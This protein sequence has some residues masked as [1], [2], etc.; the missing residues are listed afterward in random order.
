M[1]KKL[2]TVDT[3]IFGIFTLSVTSMILVGC[4][5]I[6]VDDGSTQPKNGDFVYSKEDSNTDWLGKYHSNDAIF[7][8]WV[9]SK[10][11]V[12]YIVVNNNGGKSYAQ[13]AIVPRY[14]AD[15]TL[16]ISEVPIEEE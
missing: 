12:N 7:N 16:Y 6:S 4:D 5:A 2:L 11:G 13:I 14:N 10:T 8:V 3:L 9:D 1:K 15:G